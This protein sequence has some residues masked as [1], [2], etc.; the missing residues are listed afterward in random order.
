M[1]LTQLEVSKK[2]GITQSQYS[3]IEKSG[4]NPGKYLKKLREILEPQSEDA[5]SSNI[6]DK[7]PIELDQYQSSVVNIK[8]EKE[9]L[10]GVFLN[11]HGW[12][13]IRDLER[14]IRTIRKS[15][16]E[17]IY[18]KNSEVKPIIKPRRTS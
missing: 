13:N 5:K 4:S 10:R 1:G 6:F 11:L 15:E 14:L 18:S 17:R 9:Q 16:K 2:L 3:R 8:V 12:F 7:N